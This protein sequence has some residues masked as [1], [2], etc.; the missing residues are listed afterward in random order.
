VSRAIRSSRS[1]AIR[2]RTAPTR[3]V[4]IVSIAS[5]IAANVVPQMTQIA[6]KAT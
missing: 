2:N 6:A 1:P 5:R 3:R 4:G